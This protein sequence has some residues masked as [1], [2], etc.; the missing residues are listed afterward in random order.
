MSLTEQPLTL[1]DVDG[2]VE[3]ILNILDSYDAQQQCELEVVHFG[4]GDI[5]ENDVNMA[6]MFGGTSKGRHSRCFHSF[7]VQ[8]ILLTAGWFSVIS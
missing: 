1:G 8:Q 5:S 7:C 4:I 6:E 3:A 2:S